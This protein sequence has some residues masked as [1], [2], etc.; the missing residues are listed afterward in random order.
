[1]GVTWFRNAI[2][3]HILVDRFAGY[4]TQKDPMLPD[5]IGGTLKGLLEKLNYLHDLGINTLW[6]SPVYATRAYHG[7]H[8][9]DFYQTDTR[10]GTEEDLKQLIDEAHR[11]SIRVVLDFVPNHCSR[12]HPYFIDA[13]EHKNSRYR[14]WFYFRKYSHEYLS[15]LHFSDLPKINLDYPAARNHIVGAARKWLAIGVDGFRLDHAVGPSH[16]FWKTFR[17]EVKGMNLEAVLIGEAWLENI[18][19]GMLN[20]LNIKHKYLRFLLGVKP[21]DLQRDYA[22]VFDGVLDFYFHHQA[23]KHIAYKEEELIDLAKIAHNMEQHY[24]ASPDY[25]LPSFVDNHDMDRFLFVA[26]QSREKLKQ[27]LQLQFS[28]PQPP[29]LYYGTETGMTQSGSIAGRQYYG[30]ILARQPMPWQNLDEELISFC[31]QIIRDRKKSEA[32]NLA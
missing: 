3:Y 28:L 15:F 16:D 14:A 13:L 29:I 18:S 4:D 2:V 6:L 26:G 9:I 20:T 12:D 11:K 30:D 21:G 19:A 23:V 31:Q 24:K 10:F 17:K 7:Y 25:Y 22:G 1:M 32:P 27:A 5:F 8:I